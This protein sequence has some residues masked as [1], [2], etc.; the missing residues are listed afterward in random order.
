M[1]ATDMMSR[2]DVAMSSA[3]TQLKDLG[4]AH[5]AVLAA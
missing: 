1:A 5:N 4:A 3:T 2:P